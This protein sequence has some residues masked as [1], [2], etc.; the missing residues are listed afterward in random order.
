MKGIL[1]KKIGMTSVFSNS[2]LQIPVTLIE[3]PENIVSLVRTKDKDNYDALQLSVFD[4]KK[5]RQ[6]KPEIGHFKKAKTTPKRFVK[7]IR[8]FTGFE[9]GAKVDLSIFNVGEL[10]DVTSVSKGKGFSGTIKRHNQAILAKSHGGGGGSKPVRLTGSIGDVSSNRVFKGMT[11]PGHMGNKQRTEQN[12]EIIS[13]N[14][15]EKILLVKGSIPG[16]NKSFVVIKEAVKG[17]PSK[18]PFDLLNIK[19]IELKNELLEEAKKYSLNINTDMTVEE[20]KTKLEEAKAKESEG[21][22]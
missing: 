12:L 6:L 3:V 1:G 11:M 17:L 4:K 16:P 13:I 18:T 7:E 14:K 20:M 2:G 5:S 19:Q 21:K 9:L 22:K 8:N 15:D 10:V